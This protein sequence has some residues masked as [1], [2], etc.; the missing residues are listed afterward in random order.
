[1]NTK[2]KREMNKNSACGGTVD[3]LALGA[4]AERRVGSSPTKPTNKISLE[5]TT[6]SSCENS[7]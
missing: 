4:S 5:H 7:R 1:M 2:K 3:T 6:H